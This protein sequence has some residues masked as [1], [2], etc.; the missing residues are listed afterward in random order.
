MPSHSIASVN[1]SGLC[2]H[3]RSQPAPVVSSYTLQAMPLTF[4]AVTALRYAQS[5][6][7]PRFVGTQAEADT[8]HTLAA[9]LESFGY[10]VT[11]Q[12]F[13]FSTAVNVVIVAVIAVS[14]GWI[15]LTLL[16]QATTPPVA[17]FTG[18]GVLLT[19][20][21]LRP[22]QRAAE[23]GALDPRSPWFRI[24]R[25]YSAHNLLAELPHLASNA[26]RPHLYLIAHYDSKSQRI[27]I[28]VRLMCVTLSLLGSLGTVVGALLDWTTLTTVCGLLALLAGS[29]LLWMDWADESPGAID[30]ASGVGVVLHLAE[31]LAQEADLASRLR[32][33][34]V[35]TSA[36]EL[37]LMGAAALAHHQSS[38]NRSFALNFDGIG[39]EGA[40]YVDDREQR[41]GS[42]GRLRALI[43]QVGCD[44]GIPIRRFRLPGVL[45]DHMPLARAGAD[46]ATLFAIGAATWAVHT[47]AD[48]AEKLH[49]RGFAQAGAVALRVIKRLINEG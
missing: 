16:A 1:V 25:R 15:G 44:L 18:L 46:A 9:H 31:V 47:P 3:K 42:R 41:A 24:G 27:P 6:S 34:V 45:F 37:A 33:T 21:C 2:S 10:H 23:R 14:M 38:L 49:V 40:W 17:L 32:W 26:D 39:V 7:Q 8:A 13:E 28:V 48:A 5:I 30:N 43:Q 29:P 36:E 19:L 35:L 22:L 4:S 12:P 20:A 11:R